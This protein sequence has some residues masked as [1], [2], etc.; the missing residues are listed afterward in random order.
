MC[1]GLYKQL[2]ELQGLLQE[3]RDDPAS[4]SSLKEAIVSGIRR[5]GLEK[6]CPFVK[7][8]PDGATAVEELT[9]DNVAEVP[10]DDFEEYCSKV[11]GCDS[12]PCLTCERAF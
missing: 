6:D 5:C 2:V 4:N 8:G 12:T 10:Q 1:A 3:Y 7:K 11:Y 9:E